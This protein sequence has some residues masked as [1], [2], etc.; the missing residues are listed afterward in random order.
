VFSPSRFAPVGV[1]GCVAFI[2]IGWAA[3]TLPTLIRSIQDR[4]G[5]DDAG[6]GVLYLLYAVAYASGSLV[7]GLLVERVGRRVVLA[8][9]PLLLAGGLVAMALAPGWAVFLLA[10]LPMAFGIGSVDGGVNG[11]F[12][13]AFREGRGRALN[14]L[15]VFFSLGALGSPLVMGQLVDRGVA[16]Q[17]I[18]LA[19][20][21]AALPVAALFS[22]LAMP[23]GRRA[24][25]ASPETTE[26]P[27]PTLA[28]LGVPIVLLAIAI[29][30]YVAGQGGVT[31][32]L[33]RFL[34]PAP[35]DTA[36]FTLSLY[37]AGLTVGR[38]LS[39]RVADRFDHVRFTVVALV[40][41]GAAWLAAVFVPVLPA[42]MALF[43]LA[44][45]VSAPI[46]PMI[47]VIAGERYPDRSGA[48][49]GVLATS[50]VA[51]TIVYPPVMGFVSV[52]VGLQVAM[53]GAALLLLVSV[54]ALV[55]VGRQPRPAAGAARVGVSEPAR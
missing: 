30:F 4:F 32:W 46:Y 19:M 44:G 9:G 6:I 5:Q 1:L 2:L 8:V 3:L 49:S 10:T 33:V 43:T 55:A 45:F 15:H 47:M 52:A 25:V 39:V 26:E 27:A 20:A 51:G 36:T 41:L 24:P 40:L 29:A 48:V 12:L 50:A 35:L 53:V 54:A 7:G 42:Q 37:W 17:A 21:V 22:V 28:R 31:N 13:D 11:L 14:T 18:L 34:E 23:A 38:I 16:W